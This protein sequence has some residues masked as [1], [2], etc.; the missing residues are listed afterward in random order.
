MGTG[1]ALFSMT[2]WLDSVSFEFKTQQIS[3]V[4]LDVTGLLVRKQKFFLVKIT[5]FIA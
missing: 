4:L 2:G 3:S 1:S 5:I